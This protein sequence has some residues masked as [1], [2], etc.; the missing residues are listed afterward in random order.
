MMK[1][2]FSEWSHPVTDIPANGLSRERRLTGDALVSLAQELNMLELSSVVA[3]YRID[4]LAGGAYRLHGR[5]NADGAQACVITLEPVAANIDESFDAEFWPDLPETDGGEEKSIVD[6]RDVEPLEDGVI[7]VGRIVF[8]T[9]SS[10]LD[11]YPRKPDAEFTWS[12][13]A[14]SE[15]Q[16]VSPFAALSKLKNKP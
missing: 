15:T 16:N 14:D 13:K 10:A 1:H 2:P 6:E 4:R 11:P 8:E 7:P 12:E 9:I 3:D 5:V